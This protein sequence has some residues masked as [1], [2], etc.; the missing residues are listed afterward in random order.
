MDI[1]GAELGDLVSLAARRMRASTLELGIPPHQFRALRIIA[2]A[3][4]RPARLAERLFITP[5]AV[6][7]VVDALVGAG[8]I[9]V[10]PDPDDRRAKRIAIT[11]EG[12]RA[13]GRARAAREAAAEELFAQLDDA[14]RA[15]LHALLTR[16]VGDAP[17]HPHR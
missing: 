11:P 17:R 9:V 13:L 10:E 3:P 2:H 15:T 1:T 14:D 6:T 5:R 8:L 16:V 7:D 4:V 12:T